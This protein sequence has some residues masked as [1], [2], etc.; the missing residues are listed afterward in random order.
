MHGLVT[1]QGEQFLHDG[2]RT[3]GNSLKLKDKGFRL[4][5]RENFFYS[6][7]NWNRLLR[8]AVDV[9]SIE[10]LK[11]WLDGALGSLSWWVAACSWQ[12]VG[13][14]KALRSLPMKT[15]L[16]FYDKSKK[17][18]NKQQRKGDGPLE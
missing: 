11:A 6:E 4:D 10:A 3:G 5:L 18:S 14:G 15:T 8:E 1:G 17:T 7:S 13:T 2:N 9:P 16:Q 12:G